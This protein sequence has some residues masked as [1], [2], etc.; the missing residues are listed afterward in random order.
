M[1]ELPDVGGRCE[2]KSCSR[3][4]FLPF[5]CPLCK[6]CFCSDHRF[7]HGCDNLKQVDCQV[8]GIL[9]NPIRVFMCSFDGCSEAESI[10]IACPHCEKNYCLK[11]RYVDEHS[12]EAFRKQSKAHKISVCATTSSS[13]INK[14]SVQSKAKPLNETEGKKMDRI[15]IMRLKMNAKIAAEVPPEERL[16]LFVEGND[17]KDRQAVLVSQKW[18]IGRCA[19]SIRKFIF[20]N[21]SKSLQIFKEDSE[22]PLDYAEIVSMCL[23]DMETVNVRL[24]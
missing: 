11:H 2:L 23:H 6:C 24:I 12:C 20:P 15:L 18:T 22:K 3:L 13:I 21:E 5:T 1:A 8:D 7:T 10:R 14:P 17:I 19:S 4:D 9:S 16:F